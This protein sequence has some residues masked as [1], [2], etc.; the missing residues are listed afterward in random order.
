MQP[1][2]IYAIAGERVEELKALLTPR[3]ATE[4]PKGEYSLKDINRLDVVVQSGAAVKP[5]LIL[6]AASANCCTASTN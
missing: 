3:M 2:R 5:G 1:W 4:L 6:G